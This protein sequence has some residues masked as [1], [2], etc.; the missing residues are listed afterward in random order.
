MII[1]ESIP[2]D[3]MSMFIESYWESANSGTVL[4]APEG[5]FHIIY[6]PSPFVISYQKTYCLHS[7]FYLFPINVKPI[8]INHTNKLTG[9]RLKAFT[10]YKIFNNAKLFSEKKNIYWRFNEN[11]TI[12]K[13]CTPNLN[14]ESTLY[15]P[16]QY[17]EELLHEILLEKF[18]LNSTLRDGVNYI[19]SRKGQ[20]KINEMAR[21][22]GVSRQYLYKYFVKH[23]DISPKQ[24]SAI[25]NINNFVFLSN[26]QKS[27]TE[28]AHSA[29]YFDQSHC[30]R[31]FKKYFNYSPKY[32]YSKDML[33][34]TNCINKRFTNQYNP[35]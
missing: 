25:W 31:E 4:L 26:K 33:F 16:F 14:R 30:I 18:S 19:L 34:T 11:S 3:E 1:Q 32:L 2:H 28:S 5:T 21:E 24:L 6:S 27:L 22:F 8:H 17:F 12:I 23:L 7:G 13:Y 10:F 20:I 29:G 15:N 35:K 9:I